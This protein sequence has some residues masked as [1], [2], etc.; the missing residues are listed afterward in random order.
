[1]TLKENY[2]PVVNPPR[3]FPHSPKEWL[4]REIDANVKYGVLVKVD[5]PTDWVHN[6]VV[7]ERTA[8]VWIQSILT[9]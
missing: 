2:T 5:C 6:L 3:R 8:Y 4:W 1:M 7:V 9:M